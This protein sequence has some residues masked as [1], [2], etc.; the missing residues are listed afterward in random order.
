MVWELWS[1]VYVFE[2]GWLG[3]VVVVVDVGEGGGCYVV[4]EWGC[5]F[6]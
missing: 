6:V 3:V 1:L 4:E 2:M 5:E